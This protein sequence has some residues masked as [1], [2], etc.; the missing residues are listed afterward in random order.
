MLE[1]CFFYA[2]ILVRPISDRQIS[3]KFKFTYGNLLYERE[4]EGERERER[5]PCVLSL[6]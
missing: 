6:I 3:F 1:F 5:E 4:R 2:K